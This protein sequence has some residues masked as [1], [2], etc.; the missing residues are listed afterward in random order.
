MAK[1]EKVTL[2]TVCDG[3]ATEVFQR[4]LENILDNIQDV[5]TDPEAKRKIA[6]V[7]TISPSEDR[8]AAVVTM[9]C[10]EKTVPCS[11]IGSTILISRSSGKREAYAQGAKQEPLFPQQTEETATAPV[12]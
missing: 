2:L 4:A 9:D 11:S 7:F 3:A 12:N 6:L 8:A 10:Q 1:F 5:N